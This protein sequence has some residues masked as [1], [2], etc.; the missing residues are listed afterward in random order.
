MIS[1]EEMFKPILAVS[2]GFRPIW[3][4][5]VSEWEDEA[6]LPQYLALSDL[7]TYISGLVTESRT[8]ELSD[9][10]EVIER[11]LIEGD[12]YVREAAIVGILEDL[13]NTNVV[14]SDVPDKVQELL[15]PESQKQWAKIIEFW[16]TGRIISE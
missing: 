1:K 8:R 13:Q 5:F 12:G 10:F 6:E 3:N 2:D 16:D 9:I 4:E 11:W 15:P 7:A 14:G